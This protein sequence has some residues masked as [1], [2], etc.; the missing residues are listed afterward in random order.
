LSVDK[1]KTSFHLVFSLLYGWLSNASKNGF[2]RSNTEE[3]LLKRQT[4]RQLSKLKVTQLA[5]FVKIKLSHD[6]LVSS[7]T[8]L[9]V[10]MPKELMQT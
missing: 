8:M 9:V 3:K 2:W 10:M 5:K 4:H 7:G 6:A 1:M